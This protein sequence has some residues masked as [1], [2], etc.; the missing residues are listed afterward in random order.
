MKG[1]KRSVRVVFIT[2]LVVVFAGLAFEWLYVLQMN[3]SLFTAIDKADLVGIQKSLSL[4]ANPNA[5]NHG[6]SALAS[7]CFQGKYKATDML[8]KAGANVNMVSDTGWT[9]LMYAVASPNEDTVYTVKAV[10]RY[11]P[12]VNF[13]NG[14][15]VNALNI[16]RSRDDETTAALLLAAGARETRH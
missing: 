1:R 7:A 11:R 4:G 12:D 5:R 6:V 2:A 3:I 14:Y 16:A 8:V 13:T 15:G 10:L 9:P